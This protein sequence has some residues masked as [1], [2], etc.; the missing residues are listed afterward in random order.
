[1]SRYRTPIPICA[2]IAVLMTS[3][4]PREVHA[5]APAA[6]RHTTE[7]ID[8]QP[9]W[10]VRVVT[11]VIKSDDHLVKGGS[12]AGR[13]ELH[14]GGQ[15]SG[16]A[17]LAAT[18]TIKTGNDLVGYEVSLYAV[19]AR[20]AGG[21][22]VVFSSAVIYKGG[23][24]TE[25]SHPIV[26]LFRL[27]GKDRFVRILHLAWGSHGEHEA[28]ILAANRR[29]LLGAFARQVEYHSSACGNTQDV[30][31]SWI[32]AGIAVIPQRRKIGGGIEQW[33]AAF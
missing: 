6:P 8:L 21:V 27:A 24:K 2:M 12:V 30:F 32:P 25:Q 22:R 18:I 19:K 13:G 33:V 23:K 26:P 14:A 9:G 28:A 7:W 31:C 5:P 10:R 29:N 11:P 3:C 16:Q 20:R 15:S 17:P 1:M 4:A